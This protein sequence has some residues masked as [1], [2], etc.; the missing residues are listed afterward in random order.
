VTCGLHPPRRP[1]HALA[2][3]GLAC[4]PAAAQTNAGAEPRTGMTL[5]ETTERQIRDFRWDDAIAAYRERLRQ[6]PGDA[7]TW[8]ELGRVL[9][10]RGKLEESREAYARAAAID[11]ESADATLGIAIAYRYDHDFAAAQEVYDDALRRWPADAEV[12]R[13]AGQFA[14]ERTPRLNLFY[15]NDL[16]FETREAGLTVPVLSREELFYDYQEEKR[17]G[18]YTRFDHRFGGQHFFGRDHELEIRV[19]LS[20]YRYRTPVDDFAAIDRFQE[21][22]IRYTRAFGADQRATLR[23]TLRPTRLVG[24]QTFS[25]HKVEAELRSQWSPRLATVVGSGVLRDLDDGATSADDLRTT[26]LVRAG[27][28]YSPTLRLQ[29]SGNYITNPDLDNTIHGT[30]LGQ[31]S[32]TFDDTWSTLYRLRWDDYKADGD[33]TAHYLGLRYAP[34]GHVWT[35]AGLKYV[36]RGGRSGVFPLVSLVYRY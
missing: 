27:F 21:Y 13:A 28:E 5:E 33:Q 8:R 23:Y 22:R 9:R 2:L 24:G 32:Y 6:D 26:F 11:P 36:E 17:D 30:A 18:A 29:L 3:A 10:W 25:A 34:G 14:R 7:Q 35:E 31:V 15:E 1:W 20:D 4:T 12:A 19:R 16:S